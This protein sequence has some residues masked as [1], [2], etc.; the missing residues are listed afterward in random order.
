MAFKLN[1]IHVKTP[2]PDA[3]VK[4]YVET[5]GAKIIKDKMAGGG[6]RIDLHGLPMNV[7]R[8]L[9]EQTHKQLYGFEHIAIDTDDLAGTVSKLKASGAKILEECKNPSGRSVC[10]F[11]GPQ[12]ITLEVIETAK[13]SD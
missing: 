4:W 8:F 6:Y 3:T 2:D 5:L 7:S 1:H 9:D 13:I 10:F 11:E 12:G